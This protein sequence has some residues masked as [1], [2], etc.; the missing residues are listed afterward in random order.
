[1]RGVADHRRVCHR[2]AAIRPRRPTRVRWI[3]NGGWSS[4]SERCSRRRRALLTPTH[5]PIRHVIGRAQ[6]ALTPH[7]SACSWQP[8]LDM[9]AFR[10]I[11]TAEIWE[12]ARV[13]PVPRRQPSILKSASS[14][15]VFT[16]SRESARRSASTRDVGQ[17]RAPL[18]RA[19]YG[20]RR[21]TASQAAYRRS[22]ATRRRVGPG[23]TRDLGSKGALFG[24]FEMIDVD[25][26]VC[27]VPSMTDDNLD[28]T[29]PTLATATGL[30]DG[31]ALERV[32]ALLAAIGAGAKA[33][34]DRGPVWSDWADFCWR[35]GVPPVPADPDLL[36]Q[37]IGDRLDD[38]AAELLRDAC[39]AV[40]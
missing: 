1:M 29:W 31:S 38:A 10:R 40:G 11:N 12:H 7:D 37:Y 4:A 18:T 19:A 13:H 14:R 25:N 35:C 5:T 3:A 30:A 39:K 23:R 16:A 33:D 15:S 32:V 2:D 8:P 9:R 20:R 34:D 24:R 22:L 17:H 21:S 6:R 28:M 36:E 27:T 26:V